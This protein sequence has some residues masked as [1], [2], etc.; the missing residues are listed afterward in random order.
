MVA[1]IM[2]DIVAAIIMMAIVEVIIATLATAH[3]A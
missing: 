3:S 2:M 1:I